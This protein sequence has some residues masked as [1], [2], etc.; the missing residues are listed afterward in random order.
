M[1]PGMGAALAPV[2]SMEQVV[3]VKLTA[4][5][6]LVMRSMQGMRKR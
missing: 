6:T 5:L 2:Q 1:V 3:V 4:S